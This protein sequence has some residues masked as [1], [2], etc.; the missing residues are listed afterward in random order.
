MPEEP[1]ELELAI[2]GALQTQ[3]EWFAEILNNVRN[4]LRADY[5][6]HD[7]LRGFYNPALD[8]GT[9]LPIMP[10]PGVVPSGGGETSAPM[11]TPSNTDFSSEPAQWHII[12]WDTTEETWVQG[13]TEEQTVITARQYDTT[14]KKLQIKTR[15]V[16]VL[17]IDDE[18]ESDWTLVT[19]GQ[20]EACA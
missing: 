11:L 5:A 16:R 14:S 12:R 20:A 6:S 9:G 15:L 3:A 1:T 2:A 13:I 17:V 4:D 10:T 18:D 19:G 7:D 8:M